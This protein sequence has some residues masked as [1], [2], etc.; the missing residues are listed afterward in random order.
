MSTISFFRTIENKHDMYRGKD[1]M[2]KFCEFLR[3]CVMKIINF[4]KKK[5]KLLIKEQ[6]GSYKNSKIYYICKKK[7]KNKY[8][9]DKKYCKVRDHCHFTGEYR[10][11]AYRI[12]NLKYS[13][14]RKIPI[15]FHNRSNY[16]YHFFIKVLAEEFEKQFTL[17]GENAD[18]YITFA[19]L[20]E[21]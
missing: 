17:L 3:E 5:M 20:V 8:L 12:C 6:Q 16:G 15:V 14:P 4:K 7:F 10:G 9:K 11:A 2:K 19:V 13:A 1:C 18:I 21:K